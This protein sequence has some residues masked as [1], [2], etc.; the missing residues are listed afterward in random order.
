MRFC[1]QREIDFRNFKDRLLK[2]QGVPLELALPHTL[3]DFLQNRH[4][5]L[6]ITRHL[7][8]RAI[9]V[10]SI[11]APH[12]HISDATF[13]T[14]A[15]GIVGF[16]EAV[17]AETVVFFPEI[18]SPEHRL[19]KQALALVN[20][21][22]LQER[23][24]LIIGVETV[25]EMSRILT[26]SEIM[27]NNLP[28]VL[29]TSLISKPDITWILESYNTHVVNVHL[30]AVAHVGENRS[31]DKKNQP[32]DSDPFCLDLL[33]RLSELDWKGII[34]LE[35]TPWLTSKSLEDRQLLEQIYHQHSQNPQQ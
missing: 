13:R 12:G 30:S 25:A 21:R 26:P 33:D 16:A 8:E 5:L 20:L 29:D 17:G 7:K 28:M 18:S 11:Q 35:Y 2:I 24:K 27:Q 34:T 15:P 1:I 3:N 31:A 19:E 23:T 22:D 14:W 4:R 10:W 9:P 32:V 6:D